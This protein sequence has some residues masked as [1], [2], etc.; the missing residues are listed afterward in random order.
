[1]SDPEIICGEQASACLCSLPPGH[2][3]PHHCKRAGCGGMWTYD[4]EEFV[5]I[6]FPGVG[7]AIGELE[8][9]REGRSSSVDSRGDPT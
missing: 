2:E 5:V 3:P 9:R 6:R 7:G 4:G 8:P 1:M